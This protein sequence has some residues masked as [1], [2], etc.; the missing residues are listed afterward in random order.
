M[1]TWYT[2]RLSHYTMS[3]RVRV[4]RWCK[5]RKIY[6]LVYNLVA[7][8]PTRLAVLCLSFFQIFCGHIFGASQ[9]FSSIYVLY[10]IRWY[11]RAPDVTLW[12]CI[13]L[14]HGIDI[15][16]WQLCVYT[17][18]S[19]YDA[20]WDSSSLYCWRGLEVSL[21]SRNNS[22]LTLGH[23]MKSSSHTHPER[24]WAHDRGLAHRP[25][26]VQ[27]A[28]SGEKWYTG[29]YASFET[30]S[31]TYAR[32]TWLISD[33]QHWYVSSQLFGCLV[34]I[35]K[36]HVMAL[37]EDLIDLSQTT[38]CLANI[39]WSGLTQDADYNRLSSWVIPLI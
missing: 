19:G 4:Y 33:L 6:L 8:S 9:V 36:Q 15:A 34:G 13:I 39:Q 20:V 1:H 27:Q 10:R 30:A 17:T 14:S 5:S 22:C 35:H 24:R 7:P 37:E 26:I 16:L 12:I 29:S 21:F 25:A 3:L 18:D 28:F 11:I 2:Y 23:E 31:L 32:G 38:K